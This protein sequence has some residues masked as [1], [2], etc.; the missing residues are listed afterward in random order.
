[1]GYFS[2]VRNT[3]K[4]S[5]R[6]REAL[7]DS[8]LCLPLCLLTA[9]QRDYSKD[10]STQLSSVKKV[11]VDILA[12]RFEN[13]V[14]TDSD[15][16]DSD[17]TDLIIV[18]NVLVQMHSVCE[19]RHPLQRTIAST[20]TAVWQFKPLLIEA[21]ILNTLNGLI[22]TVGVAS[23]LIDYVQSLMEY[24]P[25]GGRVLHIAL[26][27]VINWL[28]LSFKEYWKSF[29]KSIEFQNLLFSL[30][31]VLLNILHF[32]NRLLVALI[33]SCD[34]GSC[35]LDDIIIT[36]SKNLM[37]RPSEINWSNARD[38][39]QLVEQLKEIQ[40]LTDNI[41]QETSIQISRDTRISVAM[42]SI[43]VTATLS[44]SLQPVLPPLAKKWLTKG[45]YSYPPLSRL[46]LVHGLLAKSSGKD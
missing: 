9:Q 16:I 20:I 41:L 7:V 37:V 15:H 2:Q 33:Q 25:P 40:I 14:N 45:D 23:E 32:C 35:D 38:T 24:Y 17:H 26:P 44:P 43:V 28:T 39:G 21:A 8:N 11:Q 4:S 22:N 1:G 29:L 6:L 27:Q 13:H 34:S 3:K 19:P 36:S 12:I 30:S 46:A 5:Q 18:L 10:L 31:K 42:V